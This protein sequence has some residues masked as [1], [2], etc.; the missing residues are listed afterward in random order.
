MTALL[1][2]CGRRCKNPWTKARRPLW[3]GESCR[4]MDDDYAASVPCQ[5]AARRWGSSLLPPPPPTQ[6][7]NQRLCNTRNGFISATPP[8]LQREGDALC[9]RLIGFQDHCQVAEALG[10]TSPAPGPPGCCCGTPGP[11]GSA[12]GVAGTLPGLCGA[13]L[14]QSERGGTHLERDTTAGPGDRDPGRGRTLGL[15]H[16]WWITPRRRWRPAS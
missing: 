2:A 12:T 5:Q 7:G 1:T 10:T 3:S 14:L 4:T 9:H 16:A 13:A 11:S 15:V 8:L 6:G